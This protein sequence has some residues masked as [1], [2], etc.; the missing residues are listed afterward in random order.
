MYHGAQITLLQSV[1]VTCWNNMTVRT[2]VF[3]N[4]ANI[5][6]N[7]K[8]YQV[9]VDVISG[10]PGIGGEGLNDGNV[11]SQVQFGPLDTFQPSAV[12][13][14]NPKA[15]TTNSIPEQ[16]DSGMAGR[17]GQPQR[18]QWRRGGI[19]QH[20]PTMLCGQLH[21]RNLFHELRRLGL[22]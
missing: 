19:L 18:R 2:V 12:N 22:R 4:A 15:F 8:V 1:P 5:L 3:G 14:N 13:P 20:H 17:R 6:V 10:L 16:R 21:G 7:G 11:I 9:G